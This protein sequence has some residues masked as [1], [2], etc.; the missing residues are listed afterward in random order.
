MNHSPNLSPKLV[1]IHALLLILKIYQVC[2]YLCMHIIREKDVGH[3]K[4]VLRA[5][6]SLKPAEPESEAITV[7]VEALEQGQRSCPGTE[8]ELRAGFNFCVTRVSKYIDR[9]RERDRDRDSG[10]L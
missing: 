9:E 3:L 2:K 4:S 10:S 6:D 7:V 5:T 1:L 8:G